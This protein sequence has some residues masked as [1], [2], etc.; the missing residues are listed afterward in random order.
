MASSGYCIQNKKYCSTFKIK[1]APSV[2]AWFD[3]PFSWFCAFSIS[4]TKFLSA[5]KVASDSAMESS[6]KL[7]EV[8]DPEQED[9]KY[10]AIFDGGILDKSKKLDKLLI[11]EEIG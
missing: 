10:D 3:S 4:S 6:N 5:T 1:S 2:M 8:T 9:I 7:G 11:E